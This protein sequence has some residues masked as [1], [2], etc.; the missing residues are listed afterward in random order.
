[1]K[2]LGSLWVMLILSGIGVADAAEPPGQD[3]GELDGAA[4]AISVPPAWNGGLVM[5]AHG[6]QGEGSGTGLAFPEPLDDH[7]TRHGYAWAASGYRSKGYRPDWFLLDLATLR[8]HFIERFGRPRWTIIHGQSMG[9]HVA[10]AA[11]ELHPEGYQGAL[12]ECGVIDGVGL[13]NWLRA[14]TAVAEY[15]SGL[16][17]LE[18]PRPQFDQLANVEFP[19]L[20]GAPGRYTERGTRFDNVVKHLMG[21]EL[22]LRIEGMA[23]RYIANL[24]P[25]DPGPGKARN[26]AAYADTRQIHY[27]IDPGL[28]IDEAALNRD[29][30]RAEPGPDAAP[31]PVFAALTGNI[32]VPVVAIHET[33]DFR[34]PFRL[35]QDYRK[36]TDKAG[37]SHLLVQRAVRAT[38]HCGFSNAEREAGFDGLVAWIQDGKVPEGDDMAGDV[39]KLGLRWTNTWDP[40]DPMAPHK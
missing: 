14:Y 35:Q 17:L 38:G 12:I 23:E 2:V 29:I 28:G 36:R 19:Q 24:N 6:Y 34:V 26:F 31:N 3:Q 30:R 21:G 8:A 1:M 5:F 22:P 40:R 25:R 4:Y 32:T 7:L 11:L 20:I 18:T 15:F 13:V 37:T 39:A 9:G 33:A 16:P 10:I 27:Q